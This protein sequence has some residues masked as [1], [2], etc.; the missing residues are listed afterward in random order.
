MRGSTFEGGAPDL[1]RWRLEVNDYTRSE[2]I[3]GSRYPVMVRERDPDADLTLYGVNRA[4]S[5]AIIALVNEMRS[6]SRGVVLTPAKGPTIGD[7]F[8]GLEI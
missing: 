2:Y 7:R 1:I 3:V 5:E 8:S 4:E 6:A